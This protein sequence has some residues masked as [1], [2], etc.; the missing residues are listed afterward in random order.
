MDDK[1]LIY[2]DDEIEQIEELEKL[3]DH[4]LKARLVYE[5]NKLNN[6]YH[7]YVLTKYSYMSRQLR[8]EDMFLPCRAY[9]CL[10]R[11]G[12]QTVQQLIDKPR[13]EVERIKN[14]GRKSL[15][16]IVKFL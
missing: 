3:S 9:N 10:K 6:N 13:S 8:I 1:N 7:E 5:L 11:A 12:I 16:Y 15:Q 4:Q 14:L 2:S